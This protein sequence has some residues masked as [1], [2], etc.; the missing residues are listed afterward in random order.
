[1]RISKTRKGISPIVATLAL[2]ALAI[3]GS[4]IVWQMMQ[5]S[6]TAY[7][8]NVNLMVTQSELK[9]SGNYAYLILTLKNAGDYTASIVSAKV[10]DPTTGLPLN[11][12]LATGNETT[13]VSYEPP[14]EINPGDSTTLTITGIEGVT[15]G[16]D[17]IVELNVSSMGTYR[18]WALSVKAR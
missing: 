2:I 11:I 10:I 5:R 9:T 14:I 16:E 18:S 1:M 7:S 15:V 17:Y 6:V 12:T 13:L 3:A 4:S 8:T